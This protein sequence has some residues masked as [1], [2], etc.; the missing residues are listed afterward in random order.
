MSATWTS[1]AH[2]KKNTESW[3]K[4]DEVV[5][6]FQQVMDVASRETAAF[7]RSLVLT[8]SFHSSYANIL[9]Y[10]RNK[11]L[12]LRPAQR[13]MLSLKDSWQIKWTNPKCFEW[14]F[15]SSGLVYV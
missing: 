9:I 4:R 12:L 1:R 3:S 8:L 5:H 15:A 11:Y 7:E 6:G 13:A 14:F 10:H 2:I